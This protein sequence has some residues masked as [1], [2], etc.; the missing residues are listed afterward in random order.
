M[1][2]VRGCSQGVLKNEKPA[3]PAWKRRDFL[4][5]PDPDIPTGAAG[6]KWYEVPDIWWNVVERLS[7]TMLGKLT[8]FGYNFV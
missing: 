5:P 7:W 3:R 6:A 1:R 4:V 8:S 2:Y